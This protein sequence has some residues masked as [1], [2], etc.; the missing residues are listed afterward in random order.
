MDSRYKIILTSR[1]VY[2]EIE[3]SPDLAALKIGTSQDCE[4]RLRRE[5][6]FEPFYLSVLRSAGKYLITCSNNIYL[7]GGDDRKLITKEIAHGDRLYVRYQMSDSILFNL[8]FSLD[9]DYEKKTYDQMVDIAN[10]SKLTV[11][12]NDNC[13]IVIKDQFLGDDTLTL[14]RSGNQY[15]VID[16]NSRYGIYVNGIRINNTRK[17]EEH[18]FF[19]IVGYSFYYKQG[20]LYTSNNSN[21]R[22]KSL[23][24]VEVPESAG[25]MQY[26]RFNR[27]TRLKL[28]VPNEPIRVLD[29]P[30]APAKPKN[31][32][33]MSLMPALGM[34]AIT[35]LLRSSMGGGGSFII[36]SAC[37]MGMGI[38]T[39]IITF[40]TG[41]HDF[42]KDTKKRLEVYTKYIENKREEIAA[43]RQEEKEV[44]ENIYFAYERE[45][46]LV[47][48]FSGDLFDRCPED[49]DFLRVYLGIGD[50]PAHRVIEYNPKEQLEI[51]DKLLL[52]PQT[53]AQEFACIQKAPI[54]CDLIGANAVGVIGKNN[55]LYEIM[56]N[57]A[58]DICV[59]HYQKEV[60]L[61][62][63]IPEK[64]S[65]MVE[66][67][68]WLPHVQNDQLKARNIACDN[69]STNL[70]LEY[71]Y[72][73]LSERENSKES[74][75]HY[76]VFVYK[77][78]SINKH[79]LARFIEK[80][81]EL[82]FTFVFFDN[83]KEALPKGCGKVIFINK[84]GFSGRLVESD[85]A[86]RVLNFEYQEIPD[87]EALEMARKLSPIYC[88]EV[89]LEG[90]LTKNISLFELLNVFSADDLDLNQRWLTSQ[91]HKSMAAPLGVKTK[92][93]VVYLDLHEKVHGPHGL[94]AGTTGS[95]KS[96][97][98]QSY[99]L[100]MATLFHP[101]EIGFVIIDFK[102]GGMVNQFK[103][104]PHLMGA[105]T[106][107][108]GKEID[109]SLQSIKAE[110]EKRQRLFAQA[111]VNHIDAY[112]RKFKEKEVAIPVPHLIIIVDEFAELKAEQPEFMKEL[113]S[114]ARIGRSLGV[115]LILATQKP[116]GQVNEQIWSNSKFKLCLK[117][118]TKEDS[119]E[120]L[121]SPLAAE[122]REP[123]RT[124]FQV[125]NNEIFELFQSA[126]SGASAKVDG[127]SQIKEFAISEVSFSGRRKIVFQQ[128][129]SKSDE[130]TISQLEAIVDYVAEHC[131]KNEIR[132]LSNICL[133]TLEKMIEFP[134]KAISASGAG[135]V[136]ELGIYDDPSTQYQ[137]TVSIGVDN[138][139]VLIIGSAQ[140]GKT[141]LLQTVIRSVTSKHSVAEVNFY[142]IDFGSMVLKNFE[143]LNHVGGVVCPAED[144]KLKNLFKLLYSEIA[145]RK[146]KLVS[147][148]VSSFASYKEAGYTDLP[149]IVLV[150]DNFTA[151]KELYLQ[152][153]DLLLPILRDGLSVGI[154]VMVANANTSGMGFKYLS[155]IAQRVA[156]YCND[157]GEYGSVFDR[158]RMQPD[159]T[160]GRALVE[161][162]KK[163]Y[164]Y[165]TYLSFSGEREI[166]R[167]NQM[168]QFV[169]RINQNNTGLSARKIP[170]IP[171]QLSEEI[172]ASAFKINRKD[173]YTV[174]IGLTYDSISVCGID[175]I[176]QGALGIIGREK[177]GKTNLLSVIFD[178]LKQNMF[179]T[180]VEMYLIDS[181]DRQLKPFE[182]LG[183]VK[184]YTINGEDLFEYINEIYDE[185]KERFKKIST[186]G[187]EVL[188][189]DPLKLVV[190]QSR[191]AINELSK[192]TDAMKKYKELVTQF[193]NLKIC[194]IFSDVEDAAVPYSGADVLKMLKENR[195]I[196]YFNNLSEMKFCD[197][198]NL[199]L[200]AHKKEV[201]LGDAYYFKGNDIEKIKIVKARGGK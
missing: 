11:G 141:N 193:R 125:G 30:Q 195:T 109:R 118:Q 189:D 41:R 115:H 89:S 99:I 142:I 187:L 23:P 76:V 44:L 102:G 69:D 161:L 140:S 133:P 135:I 10:I 152:E 197:I 184:A 191:D 107:I 111:E 60:K 22:I 106:N 101:Y 192:H 166:D 88:E 188:Q 75:Q 39:T 185:I 159:N 87:P 77:K 64:D 24:V 68:R 59:R 144:E 19:S 38:L 36:L 43:F 119:N 170:E 130:K 126:Y 84:K 16:N 56:K 1:A 113:I 108:D 6:F 33:F 46:E 66:W 45:R 156:L 175:L 153:D 52:L 53:V 34:L 182:T 174:P 167:V 127:G 91:V 173:S 57:M 180:P 194:F 26:P 20:K 12:G 105:I 162:K 117:V 183:F 90:S 63:I 172:F 157:S 196:I 131:E 160:P 190:I 96:E 110:L 78:A 132:K 100:S 104:L 198:P 67:A 176:R 150:I 177:S 4:F 74:F 79:P 28:V 199:V 155:T 21:I 55:Q 81:G 65:E 32:L 61:A 37:T 146:D 147:A 163:I 85:N 112:I 13:D 86:N 122:I 58:L 186:G 3:L 8:Y 200:R 165:Q 82:G 42:K 50:L 31:N 14:G 54:Y 171:A 121:K 49:K 123:G 94:V 48:D 179:S 164:E 80:A 168:Q 158:C 114:A 116:A 5:L 136:A 47:R 143:D 18:D 72:Q 124:Y 73:L 98:L 149:Q 134:E 120:V 40:F 71:L 151:L 138:Q 62:L 139:N 29:P 83:H 137:G 17:L 97:I 7:D 92:N 103:D 25:P 15:I 178:Q 27:N 181:I 95:G 93:E 9:F 51:N 169:E 154:S 35:V 148:K 201:S 2:E 128:K 129:K 145:A 70:M